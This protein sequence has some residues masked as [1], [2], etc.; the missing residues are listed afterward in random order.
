MSSLKVDI[1]AGLPAFRIVGLADAAGR[2]SRITGLPAL[3]LATVTLA[4]HELLRQR[5]AQRR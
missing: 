2:L 1:R 5:R 4:Q 3:A